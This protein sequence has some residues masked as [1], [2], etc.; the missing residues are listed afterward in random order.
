MNEECSTQLSD[1]KGLAMSIIK[2][3]GVPWWYMDFDDL[4][5]EGY[6]G[7][8]RACKSYK[9]DKGSGFVHWAYIKMHGYILSYL[10]KKSP[11]DHVDID[12]LRNTHIEPS[13][14]DWIL[15]KVDIQNAMELLDERSKD[16]I[17]LHYWDKMSI[18]DIAKERKMSPSGIENIHLKALS[19]L[20]S[21]YKRQ[22]RK[23]YE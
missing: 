1:P 7:Y 20:R 18:R 11:K 5:S 3:I 22:S 21:Y 12:A 23:D 9:P 6:I 2:K 13:Y 15:D 17:K 10:I 8:L 19:V 4:I 14:D 16:V